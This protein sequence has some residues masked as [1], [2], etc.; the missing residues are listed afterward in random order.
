MS[1]EHDQIRPDAGP[2]KPTWPEGQGPLQEGQD[3]HTKEPGIAP[4][5]PSGSIV[6]GGWRKRDPQWE[7]VH[8]PFD[9][10]TAT[11]DPRSTG[12]PIGTDQTSLPPTE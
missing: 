9:T 8:D 3:A 11:V 2:R 12:D 7:E 1:E 6:Q 4:S 5:V 10:S